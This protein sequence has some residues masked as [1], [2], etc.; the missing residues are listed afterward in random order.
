MHRPRTLAPLTLALALVASCASYRDHTIQAELDQHGGAHAMA[1][2]AGAS[3]HEIGGVAHF[4]EVRG[5]TLVV[6]SVKKAPPGWHA[7]HVHEHG[8]CSAPDASSAGGHFNPENAQHG[9][10]FAQTQHAGDLGNMWVAADGTGFFSL[11]VPYLSVSEGPH[12]VVGRSF[13]VHG[14][15]DDLT[16]QPTGNAGDRIACGKIE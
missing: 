1:K 15:R 12:S 6:A 10:P 2:L 9:S 5:G 4:T 11:W 7:V 3:G 13:I 16:S 8:D 14:G